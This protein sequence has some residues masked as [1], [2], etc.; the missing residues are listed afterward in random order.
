MMEI[1]VVDSPK[2]KLSRC[3]MDAEARIA[4][5]S[6]FLD[7]LANCPTD[8]VV[9]DRESLTEGFFDLKSGIAGEFLQKVSNYRKRLIILGDYRGMTS[10]AFRD[11]SRESNQT[12][13]VIFT[14]D[15]RHA[16]ELL[17]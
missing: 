3:V 10:K 14:D 4:S 5:V 2:G 15:L 12:G 7:L 17:S 6:D 9:I 8:T 16:I 1:E 13:Q 11:F